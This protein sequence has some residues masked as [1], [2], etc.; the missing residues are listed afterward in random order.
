MTHTWDD[1]TALNVAAS[2]YLVK[3]GEIEVAVGEKTHVALLA[4]LTKR[5]LDVAYK[6]LEA[7]RMEQAALQRLPYSPK[8]QAILEEVYAAAVIRHDAF[9]SKYEAAL[10][11]QKSTSWLNWFSGRRKALSR[12]GKNKSVPKRT[13]SRRLIKR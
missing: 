1:I 7:A 10:Q 3:A 11:L 13:T 12:R 8:N 5:D 2:T 4:Q 9:L 6:T